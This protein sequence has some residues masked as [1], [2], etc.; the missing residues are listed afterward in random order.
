MRYLL[1][2]LVVAGCVTSDR[3]PLPDGSYGWYIECPRS[4]VACMEEAALHCPVGYEVIDRGGQPGFVMSGRTAVPTYR[5]NLTVK[6][7][8]RSAATE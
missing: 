8:G 1:A 3:V 5:G 4:Q 7:R 2:L 6:C